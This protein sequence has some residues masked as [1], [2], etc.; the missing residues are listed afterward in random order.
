M[1]F[2]L[3]P[4]SPSPPHKS[5]LGK[6]A[7]LGLTVFNACPSLPSAPPAE[8]SAQHSPADLPG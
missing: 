3:H 5:H 1:L 7:E 2:H 6:V 8:Q 4:F